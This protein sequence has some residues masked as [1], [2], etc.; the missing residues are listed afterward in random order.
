MADDE[1]EEQRTVP[2]A[3]TLQ[4]LQGGKTARELAEAMQELIAAVEETHKAGT[5]TLQIKVSKS[6]A[7]HMVE[8]S[9]SFVVK[10]PRLERP[11]TMFYV[12]AD[13]NLVRDNPYQEEL[14]GMLRKVE[15]APAASAKVVSE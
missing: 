10:A 2:F 4:R 13:K 5:L 1:Q 3:D 9:D 6:K 8:V 15:D 12:T 14:P 11:V 7:Q